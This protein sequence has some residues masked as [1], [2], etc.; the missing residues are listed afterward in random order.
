[1]QYASAEFSLNNSASS[2]IQHPNN[3]DDVL[4]QFPYVTLVYLISITIDG[5]TR[6]NRN[7]NKFHTHMQCMPGAMGRGKKLVLSAIR[8]KTHN[9]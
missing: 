8:E 7:E 6:F 3:H 9:K 5:L 4:F 2:S 1:M